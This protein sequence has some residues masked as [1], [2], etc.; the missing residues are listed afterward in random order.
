MLHISIL[1]PL[2]HCSSV[3][4]TKSK[5]LWSDGHVNS[6]IGQQALVIQ[7]VP[8]NTGY[9]IHIADLFLFTCL[10]S[11]FWSRVN[12]N[13]WNAHDVQR[14][15]SWY[16]LPQRGFVSCMWLRWYLSHI[17]LVPGTWNC[18]V[19]RVICN[20]FNDANVHLLQFNGVFWTF[21]VF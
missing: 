5:G 11:Y 17:Q 7:A 9:S 2:M 10:F 3:T 8:S 18:L 13:N 12:N 19:S 21:I 14:V 6:I 1:V 15:T 20:Y 4:K 16:V